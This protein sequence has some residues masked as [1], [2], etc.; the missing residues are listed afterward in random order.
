MIEFLLKSEW[1]VITALIFASAAL[2]AWLRMNKFIKEAVENL[3]DLN[4]S[5]SEVESVDESEW[6]KIKINIK[7]ENIKSLFKETEN[8]F[9]YIPTDFGNE[10]FRAG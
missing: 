7:N 4:K 5:L 10:R 1:V 6:E 8:S 9:F 3:R 2:I